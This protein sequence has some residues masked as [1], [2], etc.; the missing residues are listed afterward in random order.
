MSP[1]P[2]S[3]K[4]ILRPLATSVLGKRDYIIAFG[5]DAEEERY[6]QKI[7]SNFF[8]TNIG[9]GAFSPVEKLQAATD[10]VIQDFRAEFTGIQRRE[11]DSESKY[12]VDEILEWCEYYCKNRNLFNV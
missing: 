12:D 1:K 10:S 11:R 9:H 7:E 6:G 5:D 3:P 4:N 2:S 8:A